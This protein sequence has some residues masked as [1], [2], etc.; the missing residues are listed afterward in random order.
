MIFLIIICNSMINPKETRSYCFI[1]S[2]YYSV[3]ST[4]T[5]YYYLLIKYL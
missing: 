4:D 5:Y 2:N 3:Y 1:A